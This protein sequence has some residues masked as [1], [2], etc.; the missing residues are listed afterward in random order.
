M[1]RRRRQSGKP[2]KV[3][4][5]LI[6]RDS[7]IGH[8]MYALLDTLVRKHHGHLGPARIALAWCTSWKPDVDGRVILGQCKKASDLDR[9][10][11]PFDFVI[12]LRRMFWASELVSDAQREALLDHELCH[13]QRKHDS[14]GEPVED[15][16]GRPV[17]R[18]RKHDIE[19]FTD[20]VKRHGCYKRDL[21]TFAMAIR[22]RGIADFKPCAE[23]EE[24]P[25]WVR[26]ETG[27]GVVRCACWLK[28]NGQRAD[29]FQEAI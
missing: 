15:E 28:W 10:V 25:G 8:P 23:C 16:R 26:A 2:A 17:F 3:S 12:L 1:A 6:T 20:V 24:S 29:L 18:V 19:E 9:E 27:R 11:A 14:R 7:V 5:E 4:Y 22:L 21:E 13:A